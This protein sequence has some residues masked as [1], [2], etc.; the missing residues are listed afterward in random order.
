MVTLP[1]YA[2]GETGYLLKLCGEERLDSPE[3]GNGVRG[4]EARVPRRM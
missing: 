4:G 1:G 3:V 2:A